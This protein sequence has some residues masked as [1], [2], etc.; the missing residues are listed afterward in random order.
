MA[1][2]MNFLG[3]G[4]ILLQVRAQRS[5][6]KACTVPAIVGFELALGLALELRLRKFD[7]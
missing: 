7:A 4:R 5:L 1:L 3:D 2:L 6:T